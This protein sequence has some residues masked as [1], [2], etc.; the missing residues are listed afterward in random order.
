MATEKKKTAVPPDKLRL[1]EKLVAS[2]PGIE[3]KSNF[4]AAYTAVNGNMYSMVSK[5]GIVG[6]RL[7]EPERSEFL[8]KYKTSIFRADPAWPPNKEYVAVPDDLLKKTAALRP[9]LKASYDYAKS[10]RPKA[11]AKKKA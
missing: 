3:S 6:I 8:A 10:L 9:Y 5:Y 7:P 11:T 4:G 1:Y 2:T